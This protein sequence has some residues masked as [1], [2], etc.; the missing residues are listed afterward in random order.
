MSQINECQEQLTAEEIGEFLTNM[1]KAINFPQHLFAEELGI[2]RSTYCN[3]EKGRYKPKDY[4]ILL[5]SVRTL[6]KQKIKDGALSCVTVG[7]FG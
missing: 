3:Y 1:R 7:S 6:V 2:R 4:Q 5:S